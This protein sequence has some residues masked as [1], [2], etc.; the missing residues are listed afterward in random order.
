LVGRFAKTA[1]IREKTTI[2]GAQKTT[3][4]QV[5]FRE[6]QNL[7]SFHSFSKFAVPTKLSRP[8][9]DHLFTLTQTPCMMGYTV[10]MVNKIKK[11]RIKSKAV[12]VAR[13][14][15]DFM[16]CILTPF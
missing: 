2:S 7:E 3:K 1:R 11:G 16:L 10:N 12:N 9:N 4:I 5:F 15:L 8:I 6:A 14:C 13:L